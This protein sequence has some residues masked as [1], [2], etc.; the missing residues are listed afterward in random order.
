MSNVSGTYTLGKL[1][2]YTAKT[3]YFADLVTTALLDS[4]ISDSSMVNITEVY[5][6]LRSN[7][8]PEDA[9][10]LGVIFS[11]LLL[12]LEGYSQERKVSVLELSSKT[13]LIVRIMEK[14]VAICLKII[15][16]YLSIGC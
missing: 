2:M 16:E 14:L 9:R 3:L 12:L 8:Y 5:V 1:G 15:S 11:S 13:W 4:I 7:L 6:G 10:R